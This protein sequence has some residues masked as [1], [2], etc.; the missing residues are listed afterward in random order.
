MLVIK[1]EKKDPEPFAAVGDFIKWTATRKNSPENWSTVILIIKKDATGQA[2][3]FVVRSKKKDDF[4]QVPFKNIQGVEAGEVT[5]DVI[6]D[7]KKFIDSRT[8]VRN[9]PRK[10]KHEEDEEQKPLDCQKCRKLETKLATLQHK[11]DTLQTKH[12]DL[13]SQLTVT[14]TKLTKAE[15]AKKKAERV[16]MQPAQQPASTNPEVLTVMDHLS[17][18]GLLLNSKV[19]STV[20]GA[21][22]K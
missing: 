10:R 12:G 7:Q 3:H 19:L 6:S 18:L 9:R 22:S 11:Y 2:P 21:M 15:N 8:Q 17:S 16:A 20:A 5:A 4:K 1:D 13:K 14:K